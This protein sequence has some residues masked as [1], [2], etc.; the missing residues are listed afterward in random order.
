M[1]AV[2]ACPRCQLSQTLASGRSQKTR[3]L[4][5][6]CP[7]ACWLT[8]DK[9]PPPPCRPQ[10]S[11]QSRRWEA[12]LCGNYA[13]GSGARRLEFKSQVCYLLAE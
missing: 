8:L 11:P 10:F 7:Q 12:V 9:V 4:A 13:V 6:R 2:R 1:V 5:Q 3:A